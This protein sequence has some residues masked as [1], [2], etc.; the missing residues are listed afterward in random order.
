MSVDLVIF[1]CDGVLVDSETIS[2]RV[3]AEILTEV[4]YPITMEQVVARFSGVALEDMLAAI[5]ADWGRP[6]PDR[7]HEAMS[8]RVWAAYE[9]ELEALPYVAEAVRGLD[10]PVC[11]ASGSAPDSLRRKLKIAGLTELFA[12]HLFSRAQ[13]TNGK[14]APDLFLF[15]AERMGFAPERCLVIEDSVPGVTAGRA[16]GMRVLGYTGAGHASPDLSERLVAAGAAHVFND[17]RAL[18]SLID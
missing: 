16:A 4:G 18:T 10:R 9:A 14:P 12:P 6:L 13:V 8:G 11:V 15:A 2:C 3:D 5:E 17:M 1:D 7:Y